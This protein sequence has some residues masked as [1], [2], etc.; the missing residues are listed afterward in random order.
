MQRDTRAYLSDILEA[1]AAITEVRQIID[2]CNLL[3][4]EYI[5]IN[6][7][8]VWGV[9]QANLPVLIDQC[10]RLLSRIDRELP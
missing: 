10:C 6:N 3:T 9:I 4:H 1:A 8:L 5:N 2:F 7:Q